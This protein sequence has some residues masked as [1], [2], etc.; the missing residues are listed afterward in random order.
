MQAVSSRSKRKLTQPK[1]IIPTSY[2]ASSQTQTTQESSIHDEESLEAIKMFIDSDMSEEPASKKNLVASNQLSEDSLINMLSEEIDETGMKTE[3]IE[4]SPLTRVTR[5]RTR[6]QRDS[7][8]R[9]KEMI[10]QPVTKSNELL[11]RSK[12]YKYNSTNPNQKQKNISK[13]AETSKVK[14]L[15]SK[16]ECNFETPIKQRPPRQKKTDIF[17]DCTDIDTSINSLPKNNRQNTRLVGGGESSKVEK[18]SDSSIENR[19]SKFEASNSN[20]N[21]ESDETNQSEK[22]DESYDLA[23]SIDENDKKRYFC[24]RENLLAM[25][26]MRLDT[27]AKS[28]NIGTLKVKIPGN[29]RINLEPS[30]VMELYTQDVNSVAEMK[31]NMEQTRSMKKN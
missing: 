12:E 8:A 2:D 13:Q 25:K 29:V 11:K 30:D 7:I 22:R 18:F 19:N 10:T 26:S 5:S 14:V 16:P 28:V 24:I 1:K 4:I 31:K 6:I 9:M 15:K 21:Y 3:M 20:E 23:L 27:V 17:S